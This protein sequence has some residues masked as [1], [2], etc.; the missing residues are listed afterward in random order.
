MNTGE[1]NPIVLIF[2]TDS[3][4]MMA[5]DQTRTAVKMVEEHAGAA[6]A[7]CESTK[8]RRAQEHARQLPPQ[9]QCLI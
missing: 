5:R 3:F 8:Q 2:V 6:V 1:E 7:F 4:E 9:R